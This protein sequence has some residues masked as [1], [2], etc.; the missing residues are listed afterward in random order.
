MP[1]KKKRGDRSDGRR[2]RNLD[3]M[4]V[5]MPYLLGGRCENEAVMNETFDMTAVLNYVA[6]KNADNPEFKYTMFHVICAA[7]AKTVA[8]RPKMN[9]FIINDKY[10]ERNVISLA[11]TVKRVFRD[12]SDETLAI[13]TLE[14]D[15]NDAPID[16]VYGQVKKIVS[17]ARKESKNDG[18]TDIMGVLT[19]IPPFMIR[20]VIR[21]LKFLD[22]HRMLPAS[23]LKVDPYHTTVFLSNLGSIKMSATY[24]HLTSWGT[25]SFFALVGEMKKRPFYNADGSYEMRDALEMGFTIDERIADGFYFLN[26]L[27]ILKKLLE[28]PELLELPLNE[29]IK[30]D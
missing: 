4:H 22:R 28:K 12:D 10:Y 2:I 9:Y 7:V 3:V 11:F 16:T 20:F 27:K 25:N 24:H 29:E 6:L 14:P 15:S 1:V 21:L 5:F 19:K 23:L 8:L 17:E 13:V 26:S 18:A 30:F